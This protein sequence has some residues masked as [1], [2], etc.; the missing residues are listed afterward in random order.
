MRITSACS[1]KRPDRAAR[2]LETF[3]R[4]LRTSHS[5]VRHSTWI[6]HSAAGLDEIRCGGAFERESVANYQD[7]LGVSS[8]PDAAAGG[9]ISRLRC[10]HGV[11]F[12]RVSSPI[13]LVLDVDQPFASTGLGPKVRTRTTG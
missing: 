12:K 1:L 6:A 10:L 5:L 3:L 2:P 7:T 8:H 4:H 9:E 11:L 13:D